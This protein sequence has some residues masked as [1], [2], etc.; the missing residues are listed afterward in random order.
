MQ[1][2]LLCLTLSAML[3]LPALLACSKEQNENKNA[4]QKLS[5]KLA[6]PE[7]SIKEMTDKVADKAVEK[8]KGPLEKARELANRGD[9]HLQK[10]E[11]DM[12]KGQ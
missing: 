6:E 12:K 9:E 4:I 8:I 7:K 5:D 11:E 10:L 1:K 3:A 2:K